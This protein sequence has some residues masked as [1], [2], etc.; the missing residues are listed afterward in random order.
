M[1]R[2]TIKRATYEDKWDRKWWVSN[3]AKQ[4]WIKFTKTYNV[5]KFRR[6]NKNEARRE[7]EKDNISVI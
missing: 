7:Y 3:H 5:R 4:R 2:A 1:Q 6:M